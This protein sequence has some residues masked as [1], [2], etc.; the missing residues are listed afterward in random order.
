CRRQGAAGTDSTTLPRARAHAG[1]AGRARARRGLRRR[2][3][4]RCAAAGSA[5]GTRREPRAPGWPGE[6]ACSPCELIAAALLPPFAPTQKTGGAHK[7]ARLTQVK[8]RRAPRGQTG[9]P[10]IPMTATV[11][12]DLLRKF[13]VAGPRYTSYPTADRFVEAF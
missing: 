13:D 9:R 6:S 11:S 10:E 2:A 8:G 7:R 4:P 12:P 1:Q 3:R 5:P